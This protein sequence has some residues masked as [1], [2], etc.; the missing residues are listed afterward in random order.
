MEG[1]WMS[2]WLTTTRLEYNRLSAEAPFLP[3]VGRAREPRPLAS[4]LHEGF[5]VGLVLAGEEAHFLDQA[6]LAGRPTESWLVSP[7]EPHAWQTKSLGTEVVGVMFLPEFLG[8]DLIGDHPWQ[9]LFGA[10]AR[11]RLVAPAPEEREEFAS[12]AN[13]LRR[14]IATQPH[15][16]ETGLR[17]GILR[18]LLL[19]SRHWQ[20]AEYLFPTPSSHHA[21]LKR[22]APAMR[23]LDAEPVPPVSLSEAARAS[24]LS[25]SRFAVIFRQVAGVSFGEFSLQARMTYVQRLLRQ[26]SLSVEHIAARAGFANASHLHRAFLRYHLCTPG[27]YRRESHG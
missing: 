6:G 12:L 24:G 4:H 23:L 15:G 5:E 2:S 21:M 7:W 3:W 13:E 22:I 9:S 25:R 10:P 17:L 19:V 20:A 18:L 26:T 14:E 11:M 16:W 27:Q 1:K 8:G